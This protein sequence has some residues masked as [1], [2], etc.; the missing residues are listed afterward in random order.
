MKLPQD[1][2]E[3]TRVEGSAYARVPPRPRLLLYAGTQG[4]QN[5]LRDAK[6]LEPHKATKPKIEPKPL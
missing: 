2:P 4:F 5:Y 6:K 3:E 1:F